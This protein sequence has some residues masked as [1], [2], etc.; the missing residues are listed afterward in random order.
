MIY[1]RLSVKENL[2][3]AETK[4]FRNMNFIN[5]NNGS[6]LKLDDFILTLKKGEIF[7]KYGNYGNP[8]LRFV[9]LTDDEEKLIWKPISSCSFFKSTRS[10]ETI[11]VFQ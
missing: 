4:T 2:Q 1:R 3:F 5:E 11:D 10:I 8:H 7:V 9:Q 6:D